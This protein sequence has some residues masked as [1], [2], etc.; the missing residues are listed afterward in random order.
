MEQKQITAAYAEAVKAIKE[1]ILESRYRA[2][3]LVNKEVLALY[4]A[5]GGYISI[6][7]R[8]ARWGTNAIG[9]ISELLQQELP[10]LRGF[11]ETSIKR[12]RIFYEAW[13]DMFENRPS[14]TDDLH[15]S[16]IPVGAFKPEYAGKLNFYL[17]ALDEYV[18][19]PHENP[20]IGIILCKDRDSKTVEFAF[21]DIN[22]PMGV[23]T[24]RTSSE[25]PKEYEGILPEPEELRKLM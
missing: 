10:G 22:K 9:T 16:I 11:S 2:A 24:Y 4:Y 7:S 15:K 6:Q 13:C 18:K 1:A 8:T 19:L 14:V 25:L 5:I 20:S 23:A 12:M 3:R 21:R 17:S